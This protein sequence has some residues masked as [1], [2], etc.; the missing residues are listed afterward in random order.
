MNLGVDVGG[1]KLLCRATSADG[2]VVA[3]RRVATGPEM[4]PA[5]V[6]AAVDDFI[7]GL[8]E[9]GACESAGLGTVGVAVPG[10]VAR[11]G[12][13]ERVV[14]SDVLPRLAGWRPRV[15][16]RVEGGCLVNDVRAALLGV[17]AERPEV[18]DVAVVVVGTGIAAGFAGESRVHAGADGWAGELGS[19][20]LTVAGLEG[21]RAGTLDE[22][23]SGAALLRTL[24]LP[25]EEVAARV[26]ADDAEAGAA[27]V[28]AGRALG[29]GLATLV[30]LLNPRRVVLAGGTLAY[31]GYLD[32]ALEAA[33][34]L[35]LPEPW[36]ACTVEVD[37]DPG[38]LV[39][40]GAIH[41]GRTA[42]ASAL[43]SL[44]QGA[45]PPL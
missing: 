28:A 8:I 30:C 1:T 5:D 33:A 29:A 32:A 36:R 35:A 31:P 3:E 40:R 38:T 11:D 18:G 37:A 20:P 26:G 21:G 45:G 22:L 23:A 2:D 13:S 17:L 24:Q 10:L 9:G 19:I 44:S 15:L 41:A 25:P 16:D 6:D 7:D 42:A 34:D 43:K 27:V 39:V 12:Q 14:V 4:G